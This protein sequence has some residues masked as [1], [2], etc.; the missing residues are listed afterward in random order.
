MIEGGSHFTIHESKHP[1]LGKTKFLMELR[2]MRVRADEGANR[3]VSRE[4]S[5]LLFSGTVMED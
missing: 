2:L 1:H 5:S 4:V 3:H